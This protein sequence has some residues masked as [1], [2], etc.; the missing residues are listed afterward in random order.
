M[1]STV[2]FQ[3]WF[4][5][6]YAKTD[7]RRSHPK[8]FIGVR[9]AHI[10]GKI[11]P[12][13]IMSG[14]GRG[15][16]L[17]ELLTDPDKLAAHPFLPFL[18]QGKRERKFVRPPK[19]YT[20]WEQNKF[21]HIK[22]RPIMYAG[23]MDACIFSF[24][25]YELGKLYEAELAMRGLTE[26]VIAYRSID[27]KSN[28]DFAHEA[29]QELTQRSDC[30][31]LLVDV[32]SFFEHL[33]HK[34]LHARWDTLLPGGFAGNPSHQTVFDRITEYRQLDLPKAKMTLRKHS[35]RY[36]PC[37]TVK[38]RFCTMNEY[39]HYLKKNLVKKNKRGYGIPQGSPISGLLAN[40]YLLDFDGWAVER[41][42]HD[43]GGIYQ[44]Y[45]DDIFIL[46]PKEMANQLY[47]EIKQNL[48][49]EKLEVGYK[50]TEAFRKHDGL[51]RL[52]NI[53]KEVELKARQT[54]EQ[55]Q[56][57]GFHFD[58]E[59]TS[60]RSSTLSRHFRGCGSHRY[61][62]SSRHKIRLSVLATQANKV[63]RVRRYNHQKRTQQKIKYSIQAD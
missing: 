45:S 5:D 53:S 17:R 4:E 22:Y 25:D 29:F 3:K 41:I 61:F 62:N 27:G 56:Y 37:R 10:D 20:G 43:L 63:G 30:D 57:L 24:H 50:K 7:R 9:N 59:S 40:V 52:E 58:G 13:S 18:K 32:K 11:T 34:R 26:H 31:C 46:C 47:G 14:R 28:V 42:V 48:S 6:Q 44:R 23:H 8:K 12:Q 54:R 15:R 35:V 2:T 33:D 60:F 38:D 51:S 49:T 16:Q 21:P 19:S 55:V 36:G 1:P 39:N